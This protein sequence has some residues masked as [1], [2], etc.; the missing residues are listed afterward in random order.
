MFGALECITVCMDG[1]AAGHI[2]HTVA[3]LEKWGLD[4]KRY[5]LGL[6]RPTQKGV[7]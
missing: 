5:R 3:V 1:D 2:F 7:D 6:R 4:S